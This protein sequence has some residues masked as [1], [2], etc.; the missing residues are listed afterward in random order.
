MGDLRRPECVAHGRLVTGGENGFDGIVAKTQA[1]RR[2]RRHHNPLIVDGHDGVEVIPARQI[3]D[4]AGRRLWLV[5]VQA[6]GAFT[7]YL[8]DCKPPVGCHHHF[9]L[10][11][12]S[13]LEEVLRPIGL[14]RQKQ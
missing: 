4:P 2:Q 14:R 11:H 3:D 8:G 12:S 5:Q 1:L 10:E 7:Q 6:H 9:G 13:R